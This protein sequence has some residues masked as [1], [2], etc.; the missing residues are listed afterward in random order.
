MSPVNLG[1]LP[2]H[3]PVPTGLGQLKRGATDN[4]GGA[5]A[6]HSMMTDGWGS[7]MQIAIT[8]TRP[9]W[10][11]IRAETIFRNLDAAWYYFAWYVKCSP[12]DM[13]GVADEYCHGRLHSFIQWQHYA[14]DTVY[15]LAANTT[16][17]ATMYF[18]YRQAGTVYMYYGPNY[19]YISGEFIAEG[20]L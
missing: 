6:D 3:Q 14:L 10:W 9:G 19:T 13:D 17:T 20:S 4:E 7:P 16:Y 1:D 5:P 2:S 11:V 15:K 12:A 18:G 8:P